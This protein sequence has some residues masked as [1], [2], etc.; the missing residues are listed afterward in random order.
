MMY[1]RR[2]GVLT[3]ASSS[4][5]ALS[6]FQSSTLPF[7]FTSILSWPLKPSRKFLGLSILQLDRRTRYSGFFHVLSHRTCINCSI[8]PCEILIE[9]FVNGHFYTTFSSS[10]PMYGNRKIK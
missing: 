8:G 4:S 5:V 6:E 3:F 10:A 1:S 9:K 2:H 7:S